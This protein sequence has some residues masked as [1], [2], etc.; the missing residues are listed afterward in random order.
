MD[1]VG[2]ADEDQRVHITI[3][4]SVTQAPNCPSNYQWSGTGE[5]RIRVVQRI[6][7]ASGREEEFLPLQPSEIL[8]PPSMN[9]KLE[10]VFYTLGKMF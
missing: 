2:L 10:H 6:N 5:A 9:V 8:Y 7:A 4:N 3:H 1:G